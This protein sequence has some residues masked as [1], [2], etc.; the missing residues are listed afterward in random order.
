MSAIGITPF[1]SIKRLFSVT[2]VADA[3]GDGGGGCGGVAVG[4]SGVGGA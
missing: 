3:G 2:A 4:S 1:L